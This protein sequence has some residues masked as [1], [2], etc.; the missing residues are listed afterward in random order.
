MTIFQSNIRNLYIGP[1]LRLY[2][3][4]LKKYFHRYNL[5]DL[6]SFSH[7]YILY[8]NMASGMDK[9]PFPVTNSKILYSDPNLHMQSK[10]RKQLYSI[11]IFHATSTLWL[12]LFV[13]L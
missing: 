13:F 2:L 4:S 8:E 1:Q 5:Q 9:N 10:K 3:L 7:V 6:L 12:M 11:A